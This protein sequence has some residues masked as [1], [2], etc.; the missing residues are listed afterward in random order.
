VGSD[1]CGYAGA[2]AGPDDELAS[3]QTTAEE[4]QRQAEAAFGGAAPAG[5][6]GVPGSRPPGQLRRRLFAAFV[7]FDLVAGAGLGAYLLI[8]SAVDDTQQ[9]ARTIPS[10]PGFPTVPG[11]PNRPAQPAK[12]TRPA[13]P[14]APSS[15]LTTAGLSRAKA[16]AQRLAGPGARLELARVTADQL[17]V[18]ARTGSTRKVVLVS[19]AFTRAISTPGGGVAGNEFGF[20]SFNPAVAGRLARAL[21]RRYKLPA[22]RIA[23]MVVIRDPIGKGVEWLVYPSA[24]AAHF[25]ADAR[26]RSLRRI[27]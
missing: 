3:F 1:G 12:P 14:A 19:A 7:V 25:Q 6:V 20:E 24:G 26:G 8:K 4:S 10:L 13:Q 17:Q 2:V 9:A 5:P 27:G 18:I 11:I 21:A 16:T 23:Y 15:Y 22:S